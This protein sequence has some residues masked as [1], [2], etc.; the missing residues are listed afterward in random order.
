MAPLAAK[1]TLLPRFPL[2]WSTDRSGIPSSSNSSL[3]IAPLR[4]PRAAQHDLISLNWLKSGVITVLPVADD[5]SDRMAAPGFPDPGN[6]SAADDIKGAT[7][8]VTS[9]FWPLVIVL[10]VVVGILVL[11]LAQSFSASM[12]SAL[13]S[14]TQQPAT[15]TSTTD[16]DPTGGGPNREEDPT[17]VK[18]ASQKEQTTETAGDDD[19]P[20]SISW[21][22]YAIIAFTVV[23]G[24]VGDTYFTMLAPFLPGVMH[25]RGMSGAVTGFV[26]GCQPL[27]SLITA[28]L[29]PWAL[30]QSWGDPYVML[31]ASSACTAIAIAI[32]G[33]LGLIPLDGDYGSQVT[34]VVIICLMRLLQGSCV[35]VMQVCNGQ[36]TLML[37]PKARIGPVQGLVN[38]V[39]ILG[40]IAGPVLGGALYLARHRQLQ[41]TPPC[42]KP[43]FLLSARPL[44]TPSCARCC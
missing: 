9:L 13:A 31:R 32:T 37:L 14:R 15:S 34:F 26:F 21:Q 18:E 39:R 27:G 1:S 44:A 41:P 25:L 17:D 30:R 38:S 12:W 4:S 42:L 29:V 11:D 5:L 19:S 2:E 24:L 28:P 23:P 3:Q 8:E 7:C 33:L 20:T 40:V 36:I 16:P 43:A 22:G 6:A 35:T 10:C